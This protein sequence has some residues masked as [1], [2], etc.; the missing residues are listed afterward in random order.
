MPTTIRAP[1][2]AEPIISKQ[3]IRNALPLLYREA[4]ERPERDP[5]L[6]AE[7]FACAGNPDYFT[8]EEASENENQLQEFEQLYRNRQLVCHSDG[9]VGLVPDAFGK[10]EVQSAGAGYTIETKEGLVLEQAYLPLPLVYDGKPVTSL[11]AEYQAVLYCLQALVA[12][13]SYPEI[14]QIEFF[15]D[16]EILVRQVNG[17]SRTRI[18]A[19]KRMKREV[20]AYAKRFGSITFTHCPRTEN[21]P[22]DALAN[23]ARLSVY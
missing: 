23:Q 21:K 8:P 3:L 5:A 9:S 2:R 12:I 16:S 11:V 20:L 15:A 6:L 18:E 4:L 7:I 13:H 22:A 19:Q 17:E 10:Q 1:L 14:L